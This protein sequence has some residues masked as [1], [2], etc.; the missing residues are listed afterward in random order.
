MIKSITVKN[1]LGEEIK[2]E[3]TN[4]YDSGFYV[5]E[6]T[7]LGPPKANINISDISGVDGG[8]YNS[9]RAETRNVVLS[10]GLLEVPDIE[11]VRHK[12]YQFFPIKKK[13]T[14]TVETDERVAS[15]D[16]YVESN[17]PEIFSEQESI[18]V[19][20]LCP[21]PYWYTEDQVTVFS[22]L[23]D[24]FEF[25]FSNESLN[26]KLITM[27]EYTDERYKDIYYPGDVDTGIKAYMHFRGPA[28]D[29][30]IINATTR[31]I[32][33]IN[34]DMI[35][36]LMGGAGLDAGD[37]LLISTIKGDRYITLF[38]N[39]DYYNIIN[40]LDYDTDWVGVYR[41]N[42]TFSYIANNIEN[43]DFKI[44]NNVLY[45]GI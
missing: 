3:L 27:G 37:E 26:Q 23:N 41:G 24:G 31:E 20:I 19:S 12:S 33:K 9:S 13:L 14:L 45:E 32:M 2:M 1:F 36:A 7:G 43:I 35:A 4:P 5:K 29:I 10:L 28:S 40:A 25:P 16:G 38:R 39:G 17:E 44:L 21:N 18:Q 22:G 6:I 34:T 8:E 15:V 42:N 11:T 30:S